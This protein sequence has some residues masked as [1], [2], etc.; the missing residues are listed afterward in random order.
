VHLFVLGGRGQLGSDLAAVGGVRHKITSPPHS[1]LD[2]RDAAALDEEIRAARPDVV[3][4]AAA[5]HKVEVCEN[6]PQSAFAVNSVGAINAARA[7]RSAGARYMFVS[8]DYVFAGDE[9]RGYVE[10][11]RVAPVN[12]YG[13]SKA[14]GEI[15]SQTVCPDALVVRASGLFGHAGSAGKGGNFVETMLRKARAGEAITVVHD[16][17]LSPT[18]THDM[19][20]RIL[21]LLEEQAPPGVYHATNSGRCSWFEFARAIF[22]RAGLDA[23]LEPRASDHSVVRR[24]ACSVLLDTKGAALGL[25]PMRAWPDALAWYLEHRKS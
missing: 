21:V 20:E 11:D 5:F 10:D 25:A 3:L 14:A 22:D 13:V 23:D 17:V 4:N 7:A 24:P 9:D 8:T 16:Q 12:V 2:V 1:L 18:S 6:D 15:A 19:A